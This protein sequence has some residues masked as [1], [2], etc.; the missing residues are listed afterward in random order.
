[1][2][3]ILRLNAIMIPELILHIYSFCS[4]TD[5]VAAMGVCQAWFEAAITVIYGDVDFRLFVGVLGLPFTYDTSVPVRSRLVG[6]RI[7][8]S[9]GIF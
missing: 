2:K 7:L 4:S 6:D 5:I 1:M 3:L 9:P 8:V